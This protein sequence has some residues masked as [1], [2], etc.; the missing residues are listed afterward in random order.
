MVIKGWG[1]T[2]KMVTQ[3]ERGVC[4]WMARKELCFTKILKFTIIH[5]DNFADHHKL[6]IVNINV[7]R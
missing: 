2:N 5:M 7:H 6:S 4:L 1:N 3:N